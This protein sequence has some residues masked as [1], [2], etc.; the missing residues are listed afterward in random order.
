MTQPVTDLRTQMRRPMISE[1]EV[2]E[3]VDRYGTPVRRAFWIQADEYIRSYRWQPNTD[4]RAEVVFAIQNPAGQIW[5]H[6]KAHYP[7][8]IYRLLSGGVHLYEAVEE[9]LWR[10]IE[11]ETSLVCKIEKFLGLVTYHFTYGEDVA[12]FASYIFLLRSD[13]T[14]PQCLRDNE[15]SAFRAVLPSQLRD[16]SND[17]RNL[18]GDRHG[19]GQW[20][21]L[22][23][24][25][26]HEQL[27][28]EQQ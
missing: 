1:E 11:E 8:H 9:A 21:S 12:Y 18:I 2:A 26:V 16:V 23:V 13:F 15:I 24:D 19:W 17:L 10:E 28:S 14:Q 5:L 27:V 7:M 25:V 4:R 20:R 6:A 22:A 3:L